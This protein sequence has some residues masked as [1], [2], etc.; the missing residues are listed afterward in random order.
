[1][2]GFSVKELLQD[3]SYDLR[4]E[5]LSGEKGLKN[6]EVEIKVRKTGERINVSLDKVLEK[7]GEISTLL[8]S[9]G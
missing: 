4:L 3:Q 2:S 7:I 1:M 6:G 5:I 9:E 8:S